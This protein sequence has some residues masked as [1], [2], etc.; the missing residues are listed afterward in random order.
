MQWLIFELCCRR[1]CVFL[2]WGIALLAQLL[3]GV[4]AS[5]A[6][7]AVEL[8]FRWQY[9]YLPAH[10]VG[11]ACNAFALLLLPLCPPLQAG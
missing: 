2:R 10:S 8:A 1:A 6:P 5:L 9:C 4:G 3:S 7:I 11:V